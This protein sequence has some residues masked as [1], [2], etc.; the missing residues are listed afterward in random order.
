MGTLQRLFP[1]ARR[2][3]FPLTLAGWV[4]LLGLMGYTTFQ[5][6]SRLVLAAVV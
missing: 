6:I 5:D 1:P 4:A 3:E 2:L